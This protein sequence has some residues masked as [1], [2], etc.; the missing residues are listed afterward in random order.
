MQ[1]MRLKQRVLTIIL[2]C[3]LANVYAQKKQITADQFLNAALKTS[4]IQ[5]KPILLFCYGNTNPWSTVLDSI[6]SNKQLG[7]IL[8]NYYVVKKIRTKENGWAAKH[9][10]PAG[11]EAL[12]DR[13]YTKDSSAVQIPTIFIIDKSGKKLGQYSG[14]PENTNGFTTILEKTSAINADERNTIAQVL[15]AAYKR[16]GAP[17]AQEVLSDAIAEAK[18]T[19]KKVFL[20]FHASWCH[21]CHVL[22]TAMNESGS[23]P[24]FDKNFV[25]AHIVAHEDATYLLKQNL[26]ADAM[27]VKYQ[28]VDKGGIPFWV[29]IDEQGKLLVHFTGFPAPQYKDDY[30][31]FEKILRETANA[32]DE[33]LAAIKKIFTEVSV[34]NGI[35]DQN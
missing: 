30:G 27:M 15:V 3:W 21:W 18:S 8:N 29:V 31:K 13:L 34:R 6:I 26:G 19:H 1:I 17:T 16:N 2:F 7:V 35:T 5:K 28:G 4:A 10:N 11:N 12:F 33:D 32:S 24:F 22:D 23:K 20:I 25:V 14:F 9:A